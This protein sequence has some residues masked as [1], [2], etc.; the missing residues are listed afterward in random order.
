MLVV[1]D[2]DELPQ[3]LTE[4]ARISLVPHGYTLPPEVL[5]E[6]GRHACAPVAL[7]SL[8]TDNAVNTIERVIVDYLDGR[9]GS[10][11]R[12]AIAEDIL[13]ALLR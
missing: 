7:E 5:D 8:D 10:V 13:R 2:L 6:M 4:S 1:I 3:L 11:Q 12:R 9:V